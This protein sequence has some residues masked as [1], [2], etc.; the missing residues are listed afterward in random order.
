[1][2]HESSVTSMKNVS[3]MLLRDLTIAYVNCNELT[4]SITTNR[5]LTQID[6]LEQI[7]QPKTFLK[8]TP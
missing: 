1:M 2:V 5:Q 3:W 4:L 8:P 6:S 7:R